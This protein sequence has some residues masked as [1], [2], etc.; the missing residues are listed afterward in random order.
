MAINLEV[1]ISDFAACFRLADLRR[2]QAVNIRSK[3]V[4][5]VGIGPHSESQTVKLIT[6]ELQQYS[7]QEY[8]DKIGI[9][10]SYPNSR[11]QKCDLCLGDSPVWDWAIEVKMLRLLGDNGKLN[12]NILMHILSPY[13]EHSSVL[14]DCVKLVNTELSSNKAI[15][16]YGYE[17][18]A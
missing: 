18:A 5:Q 17:H 3:E 14:P 8:K 2:P 9:S 15:L 11:R 7:P 12:D 1:F 16:I 4:Y 6:D 13:P 10:I